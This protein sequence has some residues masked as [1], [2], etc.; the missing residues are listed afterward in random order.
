MQL[1][2]YILE[3]LVMIQ[4]E[5]F[6]QSTFFRKRWTCGIHKMLSFVSYTQKIL[7]S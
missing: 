6:L 4:F 5:N 7:V 3:M 2:E 1:E